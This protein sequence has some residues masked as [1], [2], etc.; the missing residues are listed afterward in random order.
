MTHDQATFRRRE[1]ILFKKFKIFMV[2][3]AFLQIVFMLFNC[4]VNEHN[5][6][7]KVDAPVFEFTFYYSGLEIIVGVFLFSW[8]MYE[9]PGRHAYEW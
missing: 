1:K 2:L 6:N 4:L 9:F 8:L 3:S 5:L 7:R